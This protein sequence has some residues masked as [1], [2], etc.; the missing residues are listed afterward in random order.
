MHYSPARAAEG[1]GIPAAGSSGQASQRR[2]RLWDQQPM[3]LGAGAGEEKKRH[4]ALLFLSITHTKST[5]YN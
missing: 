4:R 3:A 5:K 2:Q 1:E